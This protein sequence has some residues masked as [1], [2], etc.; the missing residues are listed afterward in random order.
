[1]GVGGVGGEVG[2]GDG[3]GG[4]VGGGWAARA[5]AAAAAAGRQ[6]ADRIIETMS[7][8]NQETS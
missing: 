5:A 6:E 8:W 3:V 7:T 4:E 1:M 2:G